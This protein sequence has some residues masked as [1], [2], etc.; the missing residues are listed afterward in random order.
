MNEYTKQ[1]IGSPSR[2]SF[3]RKHKDLCR[4]FYACDIDFVFVTKSPH[5]DIVCV[6]DYKK[7]LDEITFSEVIAY[8]GLIRRGL[9][10]YIV[11]GDVDTGRFT[12]SRYVG[13]HHAKPESKTIAVHETKDWQ[14]FSEW[15]KSVRDK[16]ANAFTSTNN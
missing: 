7:S 8:N 13:G 12:I 16:Y 1:Q 9:P 2:D 11:Q 4:T 14:A 5:A 10:V 3:K 6:I 15:E